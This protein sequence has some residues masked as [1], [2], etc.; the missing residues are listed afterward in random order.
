MASNGTP[1]QRR[2]HCPAISADGRDVAFMS[3]ASNLVPGDTNHSR[4]VFVRDLD[5]SP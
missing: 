2:K 3:Y 4:D 5:P 1:G